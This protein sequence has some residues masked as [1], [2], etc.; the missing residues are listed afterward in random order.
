MGLFD[1]IKKKKPEYVEE[2]LKPEQLTS[3]FGKSGTQIAGGMIDEDYNPN[4]Q[5]PESVDTF[6]EMRKS[7][8]TVIAILK[9]IKHPILS[10]KWQ[11]QSAGEDKEDKE[12][13]DF[14]QHNLFEKIQFKKF[15]KEA[16]GYLDF[17]FYYFEKVFE[18]KDGM[19][20]WKKFAPR[21]PKS[22]YLWEITGKEWVNG[23][24]A[25]VTQQ[26]ISA[27]DDKNELTNYPTIPWGKLI[28][29]TNDREG[30]NFEGVSVLRYA[31]KHWY[32]KDLMYKVS[33]VSAERYG[34]GVPIAKVKSSMKAAS[35]QKVE[36]WLK[37]IRSNEKSYGVLTDD[38][39]EFKIQTPE[40]SG[41]GAQ[42]KDNIEHHD[43]KIYDSILAGFL[44]LSSGDGGSNA[45]SKDQSS[46][47]LEGLQS[48]SDYIVDE[49]QPHIKEL[50]DMNYAD[51]KKYP[52]LMVTDVGSISMDE[53]I[54]AINTAVTGGLL[55]LTPDD[56]AA[57]RST[58]KLPML[59]PPDEE[60]AELDSLEAQL[61]I[62]ELH[63]ATLDDFG[64][65]MNPD[66][67]PMEQ[68]DETQ[69]ELSEAAQM[70]ELGK[71]LSDEHKKKISEALPGPYKD[72]ETPTLGSMY[73]KDKDIQEYQKQKQN[74]TN[75]ITNVRAVMQTIKDKRAG[76]SKVQKKAFAG[77]FKQKIAELTESRKSLQM[78]ARQ[79]REKEKKRKGALRVVHKEVR[80]HIKEGKKA[81]REAAK[82]VRE[83]ERAEKKRQREREKNQ[84]ASERAQKKADK[85]A[86]KANKDTAL[87][88]KI[89][90]TDREDAFIENITTFE[91]FLEDQLSE[92]EA[93][94]EN[95]EQEYRE[96]LIDLYDDSE[97]DRFDGVECLVYDK[98][99]IT[100]GKNKILSITARLTKAL[101]DSPLQDKIFA[102]AIASAK[103]T[104]IENDKKLGWSLDI[105]DGQVNTFIE[106][107]KSNMQ[108]VIFNESRRVLEN[109]TLNYGSEASIDLAKQT[110]EAITFNRNILTL[111]FVTHP[112]ALYKYIIFDESVTEGFTLFKTVVPENR[113]SSLISRPF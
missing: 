77:E 99:R 45:L 16:L 87:A 78:L 46:F 102:Q 20:E 23:H 101:I 74:L 48:V 59:A 83:T 97:S 89:E 1:L 56:V 84:R 81:E 42:V 27:D 57:I 95:A 6:N 69:E 104:L 9:A 24:P 103:T 28:L 35:R 61:A 7:D 58:L 26:L 39:T 110:A 80:S 41:V 93:I 21:V 91:E 22:H 82:V 72:M 32:Y 86:A 76:M 71:P 63:I 10:A 33:S 8:G 108:G 15:L 3:T 68:A 18:V 67:T 75:M 43:R 106:G 25:G 5:F 44:N 37:N 50:V 11:I 36:E 105:P 107:Y 111:S 62:E 47:F 60:D 79:T 55:Q 53:Q 17:G 29:F 92:A 54:G 66:G 49:L 70:I 109:I 52:K 112:R 96:A 73:E 90:P 2:E 98:K 30:N 113:M 65:Q 85:E 12:I 40:G 4:L 31:Y 19:I 94:I 34:V 100:A 51:V 38:V 88:E 13:A 14:V 64:P